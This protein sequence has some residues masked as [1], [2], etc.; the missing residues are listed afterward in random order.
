MIKECNFN[1]S[2]DT[3]KKCLDELYINSEPSITWSEILDKYNGTKEQFYLNHYINPETY[4]KIVSKY[5]KK[6]PKH[7]R[8]AFHMTLLSYAPTEVIE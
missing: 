8:N 1:K 6:L 3:M 4:D 5:E 2:E 7:L